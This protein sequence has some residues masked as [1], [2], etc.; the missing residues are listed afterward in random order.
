MEGGRE[1][2]REGEE[3]GKGREGGGGRRWSIVKRE[4]GRKGG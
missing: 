3:E 4:E 2:N 1:V